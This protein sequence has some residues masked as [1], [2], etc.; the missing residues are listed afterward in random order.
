MGYGIYIRLFA[1][2][3]HIVLSQ[4]VFTDAYLYD[5]RSLEEIERFREDIFAVAKTKALPPKWELVLDVEESKYANERICYYYFVNTAN[6]S[7][8]WLEDFN[9]TPLLWGLC[10]AKSMSR[11]RELGFSLPPGSH[12]VTYRP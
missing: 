8:F 6:R 5:V 12:A 2:W 9:V 3:L 7:L 4:P 10:H 11:I 1:R